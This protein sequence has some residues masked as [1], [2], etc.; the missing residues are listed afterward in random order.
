MKKII[1]LMLTLVMGASL[2]TGCFSDPVADELGKFLNTDM[3]TVNAKYEELKAE[4][5]KWEG[6]ADDAALAASIKNVI[7]PN[8]NESIDLV[9]KIELSTDEVKAIRDKY[10][11]VLDTYKEGYELMLTSAEGGDQGAIDK[12]MEKIDEALKLLDEYNKALETLAA[13]KDM[14][15]EY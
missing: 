10:K 14:T 7:L 12:G 8:I 2:L 5:G 15:V 13:E 6:L 9:S 1:V 4:M 11:K 3:V